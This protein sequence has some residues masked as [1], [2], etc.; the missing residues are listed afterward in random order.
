MMLPAGSW[1]LFM[2]NKSFI[3]LNLNLVQILFLPLHPA[4]C[5]LAVN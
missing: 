4:K 1:N 3:S 2:L 5:V